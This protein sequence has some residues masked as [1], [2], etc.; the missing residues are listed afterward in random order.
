MRWKVSVQLVP[1]ASCSFRSLGRRNSHTHLNFFLLCAI[2][3][4]QWTT[5]ANHL[6]RSSKNFSYKVTKCARTFLESRAQLYLPGGK[7]VRKTYSTCPAQELTCPWQADRDCVAPHY[8]THDPFH[9]PKC[10]CPNQNKINH[11]ICTACILTKSQSQLHASFHLIDVPGTTA[12]LVSGLCSSIVMKHSGQVSTQCCRNCQIVFECGVLLQVF[13]DNWFDTLLYEIKW[14]EII[15]DHMHYTWCS[16]RD[17]LLLTLWIIGRSA[18][19]QLP[20]LP[21]Q[22]PIAFSPF[23]TYMKDIHVPII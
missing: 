3:P 17:R 7:V 14:A 13:L 10:H 5:K 22:N 20:S 19:I 2:S 6:L 21:I 23:E 11:L 12:M 9:V 8:Q 18:R 15:L 1:G 4:W 16:W